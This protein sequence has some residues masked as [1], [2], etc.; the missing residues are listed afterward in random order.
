MRSKLFSL[1]FLIIVF[2]GFISF[3][4]SIHLHKVQHRNSDS[5]TYN[6]IIDK[7]DYELKVYD[8]EGWYA[9]YPVVFGS[10]DLGDKMKEG[11]K[12]TPN[13]NFKVLLK[14]VHIKWGQEL[15]LDYPTKENI[16][17]FNKRKANGLIPKTARI[18]N[19][20]A[21]HGTRPEEEWTIDN[22][23]GWTDGCVSL[24]YTEMQDLFAYIPEGTKVKIQP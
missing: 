24:K 10:K 23:Y 5:T 21:I 16:E 9:T 2:L 17:L 18:G 13:G 15:L 1:L 19:G 4:P 6:I 11:D 20:I 3:S 22:E 12:R 7:S 8:A 14:K